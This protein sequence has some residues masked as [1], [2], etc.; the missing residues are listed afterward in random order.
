MIALFSSARA[1][2]RRPRSRV[3]L[4]LALG[5]GV[6][7]NAR[8]QIALPAWDAVANKAWWAAHP[9]PVTWSKAADALQ[10]QLESIYQKSGSATFSQPDFQGWME[11][12]E[13]VRLGLTFPDK[14]T[15]PEDLAG[16]VALGQDDSISHLLVEKLSPRDDRA[17]ALQNLLTLE[18]AGLGD[19]HD[20]AALGVAYALVFDEPFPANW[21]HAQVPQGTLPI[22]DLDIVKRFQ[23]YV[24]A[25]KAK[26]SI[27]I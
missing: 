24:Q 12:L 2:K 15:K 25:N 18:Q 17:S 1:K 8:G 21:P 14:F 23:F 16:F 5:F 7:L 13:W 26:N 19:L 9:T 6:I 20:Y 4:I 27:W 22:G 11:H 10:A 3:L